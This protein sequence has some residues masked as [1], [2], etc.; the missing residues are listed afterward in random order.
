[1]IPVGKKLGF[2]NREF[3]KFPKIPDSR[4]LETTL[5]SRTRQFCEFKLSIM[6]ISTEFET[7]TDRSRPFLPVLKDFCA[8]VF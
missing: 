5:L 4:C 7:E 3:R 2:G 6:G 8:R 1:M